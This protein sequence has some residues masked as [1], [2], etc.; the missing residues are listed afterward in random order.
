MVM[1][2]LR[3]AADTVVIGAGT[4]RAVPHHL[5][6]AE[7]VY[8]P[9]ADAFRAYRRRLRMPPTP[10]QVVVTASGELDHDLPIFRSEEVRTTVVTTRSGARRLRSTDAPSNVSV[11]S[12]GDRERLSA[13]AILASATR[14]GA[15][16]LVLVE[17]GPHLIAD[18]V[19]EGVLDELF[20]TLVPKMI[21]RDS[22]HPRLALVEGQA[23]GPDRTVEAC[24]VDARRGGE[25]LFLRY[26]FRR[27][28]AAMPAWTS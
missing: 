10:R 12:A 21:G 16:G 6:T 24:L 19:G 5:W 4:L 13:R 20:L 27:R 11:V 18:F 25:L 28:T 7:H 15:A 9:F 22:D 14:S 23:F 3:A 2:I 26:A 8:P 17:G 1:G